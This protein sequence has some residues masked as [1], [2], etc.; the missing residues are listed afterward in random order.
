MAVKIK[1]KIDP[2]KRYRIYQSEMWR[3]KKVLDSDNEKDF[4]KKL[5]SYK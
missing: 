3:W 5:R 4:L 1:V 2:N